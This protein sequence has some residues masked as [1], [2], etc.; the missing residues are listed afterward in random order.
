MREREEPGFDAPSPLRHPAGAAA[1]GPGPPEVV[2][3]RA[4]PRPLLPV[5]LGRRG[6]A[7]ALAVA[8][9]VVAGLAAAALAAG[10]GATTRLL[11]GRFADLGGP[12]VVRFEWAL[13]AL[14]A[15]GGLVSGIVV[16]ILARVG[17]GHGTDQMVHAFHYRD[18]DLP[19]RGPTVRAAASTVVIGA[20]GSAGPEGPIAGLGAAI[21]SAA[22]RALGLTPRERRQLLVAGCAA[23]VGAIFH[24]PLGGAL[25]AASILYRRPEFEG[26]ALV[27]AFVAS[28][29]GYATFTAFVGFGSHMLRDADRLAFGGALELPAYVVLGAAC[30]ATAVLFTA[31]FHRTEQ[32][33]A[34]MGPLPVWLRPALGGLLTGL[35][36]C[37]LPQV[38]DGQYR[39]IQ[40]ALDGSLFAGPVGGARGPLLWAA[41]LFLVVLAKCVATSFTVGS[42]AAG[43]ILGPSLF[44]GGIVGAALGQLFDAVTPGGLGEPL[45]QALVPVGMA[46]VL[47]AGMRTP[48]AAIVMVVEMTGSYGLVVPLMVAT[49]TAYLVGG[50]R[51]ALVAGQVPGPA[52]SPTHA[53]DL[54]VGLLERIRVR[55]AM[56]AVWPAVAERSAPLARVIAS[57]PEGEAPVVAV[58]EQD[59]LV[60]VIA[61]AELRHLGDAADLGPL[62]IAEDAMTERFERV[63]PGDTLYDALAAI[64]RSGAEAVPVVGARDGAFLGMVTRRIVHAQVVARLREVREDLL[65]EHAGLAAIEEESQLVHLMSGIPGAEAGRIERIPVD[66][67]LVGR[68]LREADFRRRHGAVVLA[69]VTGDRRTQ[70]PPDPARPLRA[71]DR[72]VVL[73]Q[74]DEAEGAEPEG[75]AG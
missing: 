38:M 68:S 50:R 32:A 41:I 42:G 56:Q 7:T 66:P 47:A 45:R 57:L 28:A 12:E 22:G 36:A 46:G 8:V 13:L 6:R 34:R 24:C 16:Q 14:P 62:A 70:C 64:G 1:P 51:A 49:V 72:L 33:F 27:P 53:G 4:L 59:R 5:S 37:A 63:R 74:H 52:D 48:I 17:P 20:G 25:F 60:G 18:G 67:E 55:D 73:L 61:V 43:G 29:V 69:V 40:N 44:L 9:G 35:V 19:L 75:G 3:L 11:I 58:V 10:L 21:G 2:L 54:L 15:L 23:G 39:T 71:D 30:G 31:L 65:R 26:G